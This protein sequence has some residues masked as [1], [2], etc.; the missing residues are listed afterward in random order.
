MSDYVGH[1]P[2]LSIIIPLFAGA[3]MVLLKEKNRGLN[4]FISFAS[5]V[6][7]ILVAVNLLIYIS[8][9]IEG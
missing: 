5:V 1:L 3:L 4:T 7:Q 2:I 8:S 9:Y 6:A